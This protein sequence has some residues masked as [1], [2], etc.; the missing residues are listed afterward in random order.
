V[1]C[2]KRYGKRC[3]VARLMVVIPSIRSGFNTTSP[4]WAKCWAV[5]SS[6]GVRRSAHR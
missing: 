6:A 5:G 2:W 1:Y 4:H 3:T